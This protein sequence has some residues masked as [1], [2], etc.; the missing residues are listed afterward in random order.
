[1]RIIGSQKNQ[2]RD[3]LAWLAQLDSD[4]GGNSDEDSDEDSNEDQEITHS[5][6]EPLI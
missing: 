4:G 6:P 5:V 1:M 3:I 2:K